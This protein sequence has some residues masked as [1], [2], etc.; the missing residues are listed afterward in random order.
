MRNHQLT[1]SEIKTRQKKKSKLIDLILEMGY[2]LTMVSI[3]ILI[4]VKPVTTKLQSSAGPSSVNKLKKFKNVVQD[5][6][7]FQW[8]NG[9]M[10]FV[11]LL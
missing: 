10:L 2:S 3:S 8:F 1:R 9:K 4:P 5:L 11:S 7:Y 6:G